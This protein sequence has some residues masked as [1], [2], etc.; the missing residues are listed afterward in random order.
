M[1]IH[2]VIA[3]FFCAAFLV[4][5]RSAYL[6]HEQAVLTVVADKHQS[7]LQG[8]DTAVWRIHHDKII[9]LLTS[10]ATATEDNIDVVLFSE[11]MRSFFRNMQI[12]SVQVYDATPQRLMALP[13]ANPKEPVRLSNDLLLEV[14]AKKTPLHRILSGPDGEVL[15]QGVLPMKLDNAV[16]LLL[17][18]TSNISQEMQ[19]LRGCLA[20]PASC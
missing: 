16:P 2:I 18:F 6:H 14:I 7:L 10:K 17:V 12:E 5:I 15:A 20:L 8:F 19:Y 1:R 4:G 9:P 3:I 13:V 11:D